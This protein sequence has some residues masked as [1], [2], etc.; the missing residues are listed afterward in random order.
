M[1]CGAE[2]IYFGGEKGPTRAAALAGL[3][4]QTKSKILRNRE[5][6]EQVLT[7]LSQNTEKAH[8]RWAFSVFGGYGTMFGP[9]WLI[10]AVLRYRC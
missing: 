6:S 8:H 5:D 3:L 1:F 2:K 7:T 10:L 4:F 9:L